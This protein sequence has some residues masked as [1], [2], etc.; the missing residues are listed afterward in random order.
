MDGSSGRVGLE[1]DDHQVSVRRSAF[2]NR[3]TDA[4]LKIYDG[5]VAEGIGK[6]E[7]EG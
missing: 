5:D 3:A 7:A 6:D 2:A 1:A 4:P